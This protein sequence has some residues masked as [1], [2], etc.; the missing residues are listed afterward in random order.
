MVIDNNEDGFFDDINVIGEKLVEVFLK[1]SNKSLIMD[2]VWSEFEEFFKDFVFKNNL[3]EFVVRVEKFGLGRY[4]NWIFLG[5]GDV[6]KDLGKFGDL[7]L[8]YEI[9]LYFKEKEI[10]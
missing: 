10:K 6:K 5:F 1:V 8:W 2:E 7:I 9:L 3:E 4:E